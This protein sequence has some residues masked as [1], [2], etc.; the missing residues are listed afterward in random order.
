MATVPNI[1]NVYP[2]PSA[3]G[4]PIG[5]QI[6]IQF[7]QEMD[8]DSLNTGTI[9]VTGPDEAPVFGPI[10]I[11]P[12]DIPGHDDEDILSSPYFK[13]YVKGTITYARVDASGGTVDD[14]VEDTTGDGTL[15][16]TVAIFTP[17]KPLKPNVDYKVIIAGDEAP[18]DDFE[19][20]VKTRTVFDPV[21]SGSGTGTIEF[22]GGYTGTAPTEYTVEITAGGPT[23]TAQYIWWNNNDPLRTYQGITTTGIR[24]LE[25]GVYITCGKDGNFTIGDTFIVV[26]ISAIVLP[27]NYEWDFSTGSG[28]I[29]T[30]PSDSS[31][32]GIDS[33]LTNVVGDTSQSNIFN[34]TAVSPVDGKYGVSISTDPYAGETIIVQF[35]QDV[36]PLTLAGNAINVRSEVCNGDDIMFQATGDLAFVATLET[37]SKLVI[38]LEPGQLYINNIV[39]LELAETIADTDGNLL[40][41]GFSSYF[42]TPY[43]PLYTGIRVIQ[44]DLGN[45]VEDIPEE[46]IML[47]IL[48]ASIQA[49]TLTYKTIVNS[50]NYHLARKRY[51]TCLAEAILVRGLLTGNGGERMTKK[52][53]DFEVQRFGN[54]EDLRGT[55]GQLEDC[56]LTQLPIIQSGGELGPYTSVKPQVSVKGALA[57]DAIYVRRQWEPTSGV[58]VSNGRSAGNSSRYASGRRDLKTFRSRNLRG[59][60]D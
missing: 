48:E 45:I 24:E 60:N 36:E 11:T 20:G 13:G 57:E 29:L 10:D 12:F 51:T 1:I 41:D 3:K 55:L 9:V 4:I 53:G 2:A 21:F 40:T 42:S 18:D 39:L 16:N 56:M 6:R 43:S 17:D 35:S 15:W 59:R 19:T 5:D 37:P 49:D 58:G 46:T 47:A 26:V 7:D 8:L 31:T 38:A 14:S 32:S 23:G 25:N 22:G 52:L 27:N 34:V 44:M 30:P 28:A 54:N 50:T 33:V